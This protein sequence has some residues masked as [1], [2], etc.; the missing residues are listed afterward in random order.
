MTERENVYDAAV[1]QGENR[2]LAERSDSIRQA[3]M[4]S[5]TLTSAEGPYT[6]DH[7]DR[8]M[9]DLDWLIRQARK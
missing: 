2:T 9:Y 7:Y 1:R 5:M 3:L 6:H 4:I 8:A